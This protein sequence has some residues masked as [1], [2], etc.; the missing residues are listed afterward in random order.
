MSKKQGL[1]QSTIAAFMKLPASTGNSS[2]FRKNP[3]PENPLNLK[4]NAETQRRNPSLPSSSTKK[5][6]TLTLVASPF[7]HHPKKSTPPNSAIILSQ[8]DKEDQEPKIEAKTQKQ[9]HHAYQPRKKI[10]FIKK[11]DASQ[12]NFSK[13][14]NNSAISFEKQRNFFQN[15]PKKPDSK[16]TEKPK[17]PLKEV[18]QIQMLLSAKNPEKM[19]HYLKPKSQIPSPQE[20]KEE[21]FQFSS[22]TGL[23]SSLVKRP[24]NQHL[25]TASPASNSN[26]VIC[27]ESFLSEGK[28]KKQQDSLKAQNGKNGLESYFKKNYFGGNPPINKEK[29]E[30]LAPKSQIKGKRVS[31]QVEKGKKMSP[32]CLSNAVSRSDYYM[33]CYK[34]G[35]CEFLRKKSAKLELLLESIT[36]ICVSMGLKKEE[37]DA[38][39][40]FGLLRKACERSSSLWANKYK[41]GLVTEVSHFI[42]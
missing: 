26:K 18:N 25:K 38:L 4:A 13:E 32:I 9:N 2:Q 1:P 28:P 40:R 35:F 36:Q 17:E 27:I 39:G 8:N 41:P 5:Q 16:E 19:V 23:I 29:R 6:G 22:S 37:G 33:D 7:Q 42:F 14:T 31:P 12:L 21:N 20:P 15:A 11:T 10:S 24:H 3:S 34:S 30:P